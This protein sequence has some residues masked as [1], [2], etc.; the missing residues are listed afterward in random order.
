VPAGQQQPCVP[1]DLQQQQQQPAQPVQSHATE[2][3]LG[4]GRRQRKEQDQQVQQ[5][6]ERC[7]TDS[8]SSPMDC[9]DPSPVC[10]DQLM[11]PQS[12]PSARSTAPPAD[13]PSQQAAKN[14]SL[15]TPGK[16]CCLAWHLGFA[17]LI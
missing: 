8:Q 6:L 1:A 2:W 5:E 16:H 3:N 9:S 14:A 12:Q 17:S 13:T 10:Q 4:K 11:S 15:S 7:L